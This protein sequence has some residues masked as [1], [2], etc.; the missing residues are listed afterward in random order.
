MQKFSN[1]ASSTIKAIASADLIIDKDLA[2][3]NDK[4]LED[5]FNEKKE[6]PQNKE[7][8]NKE[9]PQNNKT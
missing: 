4:K 9:I 3:I 8:N 7:E 5:L 1:I 2:N 6:T